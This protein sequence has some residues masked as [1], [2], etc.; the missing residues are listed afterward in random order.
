MRPSAPELR[1]EMK[2]ILSKVG[3][4]HSRDELVQFVRDPVV[5]GEKLTA[6]L[7]PHLMVLAEH[8]YEEKNIALAIDHLDRILGLDSQNSAALRLI[9]RI[10]RSRS[11]QRNLFVAAILC[12]GLMPMAI[13][14]WYFTQGNQEAPNV[15][16][17]PLAPVRAASADGTDKDM[18]ALVTTVA[19]ADSLMVK[20]APLDAGIR[21]AVD[22]AVAKNVAPMD[23]G[24]DEEKRANETKTSTSKRLPKRSRRRTSPRPD[25]P[26]DAGIKDT[27]RAIVE[28]HSGTKGVM[29]FVD[30]KKY[31]KNPL[32]AIEVQGGLRLRPGV[33]TI[34]FR[35]PGC[36][37]RSF[38]IEIKGKDLKRRRVLKFNCKLL[39]AI[40]HIQSRDNLPV[41]DATNNAFKDLGRTNTSIPIRMTSTEKVLD[42]T[43]GPREGK[44]LRRRVSLK[45]GARL[46][47]KL[48][49]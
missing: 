45:A 9:R 32:Y 47:L 31:S 34:L 49:K 41:I 20:M 8:A 42:L 19:R 37:E 33:H 27:A 3:L 25:G 46:A 14:I 4:S 28:V 23:A 15:I 24:G 18:A 1:D 16:T 35:N 10:E 12:C 30:G 29:V 48:D 38:K 2:V 36:E 13:G 44:Y 43:I 22:G 21:Q 6:R 7:L 26:K 11:V 40:L 39:P 5:Y 17:T